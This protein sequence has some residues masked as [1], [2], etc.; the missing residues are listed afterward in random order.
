VHSTKWSRWGEVEKDPDFEGNVSWCA[1]RARIVAVE[2]SNV[3]L[4]AYEITE[5][6]GPHTCWLDG[7]PVYTAEGHYLPSPEQL[8][9]GQP[10]PL[11]AALHPWTPV[12]F[13][14]SWIAEQPSGDRPSP[15]E[16]P[17]VLIGAT[18]A[19]P[20]LMKYVARATALMARGVEFSTHALPH[21]SS[22]KASS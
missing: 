8:A 22:C 2:E 7:S 19:A 3:R 17:G 18:E 5:R 13:I 21:L 6:I 1:P 12:E 11:F 9:V 10:H 15:A 16:F 14:N 4:N 20:V